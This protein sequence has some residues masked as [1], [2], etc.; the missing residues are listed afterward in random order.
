M[1]TGIVGADPALADDHQKEERRNETWGPYKIEEAA[2]IA[3]EAQVALEVVVMASSS[4]PFQPMRQAE[5]ARTNPCHLVL[6]A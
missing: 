3:E 2:L 4:S 5:A 1:G 6:R